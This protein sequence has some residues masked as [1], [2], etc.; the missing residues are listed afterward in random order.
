MENI[1]H[2]ARKYFW[3]VGIEHIKLFQFKEYLN[4]NLHKIFQI[5]N[6]NLR[7]IYNIYVYIHIN[8]IESTF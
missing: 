2:Y 3:N 6:I 5:H 7:E 1:Y 4:V 8:K